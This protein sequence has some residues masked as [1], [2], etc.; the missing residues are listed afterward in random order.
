MGGIRLE[1]RAEH[2]RNTGGFVGNGM[3]GGSQP[4]EKSRFHQPEF[5]LIATPSAAN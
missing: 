1:R 3:F 2:A 4:V 5:G